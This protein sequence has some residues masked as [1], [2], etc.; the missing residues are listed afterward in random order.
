MGDCG[1]CYVDPVHKA[2][3]VLP[4]INGTQYDLS[5][6]DDE[7]RIKVSGTDPS[8]YSEEYAIS[9]HGERS[10]KMTVLSNEQG[11]VDL[12]LTPL[13]IALRNKEYAKHEEIVPNKIEKE[14]LKTL[15]QM[16][17]L[18]VLKKD[19]LIKQEG[20]EK[21]GKDIDYVKKTYDELFNHI[22]K[23]P[24]PKHHFWLF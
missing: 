3:T 10:S 6:S 1:I 12:G 17:R 19:D 2:I 15:D 23:D 5:Q 22:I 7:Y 24:S 20:V 13:D 8:G 4:C 14:A 16:L 21:A 18:I 9:K 11:I